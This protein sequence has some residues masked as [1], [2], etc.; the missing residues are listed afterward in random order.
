MLDVLLGIAR[1][2][3]SGI[4]SPGV[5]KSPLGEEREARIHGGQVQINGLLP[6][7][8]VIKKRVIM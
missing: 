3:R 7:L 6:P 5:V 1:N 4:I 8:A 2:S